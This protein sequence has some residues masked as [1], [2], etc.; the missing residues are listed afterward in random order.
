VDFPTFVTTIYGTLDNQNARVIPFLQDSVVRMLGEL[1]GFREILWMENSGSFNTTANQ[2]EYPTG[3]NPGTVTYTGVPPDVK[4]FD[5]FYIVTAGNPQLLGVSIKGPVP[6]EF[7]R[8]SFL[9]FPFQG[10]WPMYWAFHHGAVVIG[11]LPSQVITIGFDYLKDATRDQ[12]SGLPITSSQGV[13]PA[14]T[15]ITNPWF[16]EGQGYHVLRAA[17]AADYHSSITKDEQQRQYQQEMMASGIANL[18]KRWYA[19][20]GQGWQAPRAFGEAYD[21]WGLP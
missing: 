2:A 8:S 5:S 17:V 10:V 20:K 13:A 3:Q 14:G 9:R 1:S 4:E 21:R 12:T 6:I 16:K 18:T 15:G 11:P 7:L 19:L